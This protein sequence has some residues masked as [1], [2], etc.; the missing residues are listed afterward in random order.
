METKGSR[1]NPYTWIEYISK[2]Q[3]QIWQGG[4]VKNGDNLIYYTHLS[5]TYNGRG[6]KNNPVPEHIYNE[7]R[8]M[9]FWTGGWVD[10]IPQV[11]YYNANGT[12]YG[13]YY[14]SECDPWPISIYNEMTSNEIWESAW[15][16][17]KSGNVRYVQ[18]F[19]VNFDS[20]CGCGCGC[21]GSA[22]CG[23]GDGSA[24]CG[25]GEG[26]GDL[27][28]S[29]HPISFGSDMAGTIL[30]GAGEV[31]LNWTSGNTTGIIGLALINTYIAFIDSAYILKESDI[32]TTWINAYEAKV[33]GSFKYEKDGEE[34]L[35]RI[36]GGSFIIP[37]EFHQ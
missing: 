23:C 24:G 33:L 36:F 35:C 4:W 12:Q 27:I 20:G 8:Q 6:E 29:E 17:E 22:G 15:I 14:G 3:D 13:T 2:L 19:Q 5:A 7:M 16:R 31:H 37:E 34:K 32:R 30:N 9:E 10:S 18:N 26:C 25:C 21:D 11:S 28:E 1:K